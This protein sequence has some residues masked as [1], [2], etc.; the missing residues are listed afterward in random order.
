MKKYLKTHGIPMGVALF[1]VCGGFFIEPYIPEDYLDA[2]VQVIALVLGLILWVKVG[3]LFLTLM[4][5]LI[6]FSFH[7]YCS[8]LMVRQTALAFIIIG[9]FISIRHLTHVR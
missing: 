3:N 1:S 4:I 9:L 7:T 8:L 6:S 5:G 2:L